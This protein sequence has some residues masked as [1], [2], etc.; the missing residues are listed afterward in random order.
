MF[1]VYSSFMVWCFFFKQKTAYEMRISDWSS[2]VC[3][4]DLPALAKTAAR[5]EASDERN[6]YRNVAADFVNRHA[7]RKNRSWQETARLLGL[8]PD[9]DTDGELKP[10]KGGLADNKKWGA[11]RVQEIAR[12]DI[13]ELIDG[14]EERGEIGRAHVCTP[15]TNAQLVC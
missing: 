2:D 8:R 11:R 5:V 1:I 15:V 9:P 13:R 7:K 3:S 6:L 12:R 4:S 14:I 10:I